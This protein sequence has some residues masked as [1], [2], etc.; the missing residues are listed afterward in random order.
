MKDYDGDLACEEVD[1]QLENNEMSVKLNILEARETNSKFLIDT[2]AQLSFIKYDEITNKNWINQN[3]TI[4]IIGAINEQ[5]CRSVGTIVLSIKM[6]NKLFK[7]KFN[8]TDEQVKYEASGIIGF[9]FMCLF[10]CEI[11]TQVKKMR[12]AYPS[13]IDSIISNVSNG[14]NLNKMKNEND[15]DD[16]I[17]NQLIDKAFI[18]KLVVVESEKK[19]IILKGR[20]HNV[21]EIE[22][23][24]NEPFVCEKS[25]ITNGILVANTIAQPFNGLVKIMLLNMNESDVHIKASDIDL[26]ISRLEDFDIMEYDA[27]QGSDGNDRIERI[28]Q[29][30]NLEHCNNEEKNQILD[31][32]TKYADLFY[33]QGE[34]LS[35]TNIV[36][37]SIELKPG[38]TPKKSKSYRLPYSHQQEIKKQVKE[39][40]RQDMIEETGSPWR[41]PL[42]LV[43]KK[44]NDENKKWRL[45]MDFREVNSSTIQDVYPIP[46]ISEILENLGKSQY[47]SKLDMASGYW[48]VEMEEES[49]KITA[50][51]ADGKLYAWKRMPFGLVNSQAT[52]QRL[53]NQALAGLEGFMCFVYLDDVIIYGKSLADH[54][55]RLI[56]IFKEFRKCNLKLQPSKCEFLCTEI[57]FLGHIVSR[58]GVRVDPKKTEAV[59]KFPIPKTRKQIKSF[60]GFASYYRKF[61][62]RFAKIAAPINWLLRK[63]SKYE[64]TKECDNA[65]NE[66]KEKLVNPPILIFPDYEKEFI[67]TVDASN[68]AIGAI[69]SQGQMTKNASG[70]LPIA[71]ASRQFKDNEMHMSSNDKELTAILFGLQ[72]F[73]PYVLDRRFL[74]VTDCN[75]L[76]YLMKMKNCVTKYTRW[77]VVLGEYNFDIMHKPGILNS[78]ADAL[79]RI[80]LN[81]DDIFGKENIQN[82]LEMKHESKLRI[83]TRSMSRNASKINESANKSEAVSDLNIEEGDVQNLKTKNFDLTLYI[84]SDEGI[85][86]TNELCRDVPFIPE[87]GKIKIVERNEI[88]MYLPNSVAEN[89]MKQAIGGLKTY[90]KNMRRKNIAIV[91]ESKDPKFVFALKFNLM[92]E[93][94]KNYKIKIFTA[95]IIDVNDE[96]DRK[97]I[98]KENHDDP[99]GGHLGYQKTL[100]KIKRK[101][102]WKNLTNDVRQYV[103]G[104]V[105]CKKSKVT[106][107][108]KMPM[109]I[110]STASRPYETVWMDIV[111]PFDE[112]IYGNKYVITFQDDLTKFVNAVPLTNY[113][114]FTCAE[115]FVNE[116]I[117]VHGTPENILTDNGSNFVSDMFRSVCE[118]LNINH[119]KTSA[120]MPS[121]NPIERYHRSLGNYIHAFVDGEKAEWD[122]WIRFATSVY[123]NSKHETT[124]FAPHFLLYGK[125]SNIPNGLEGEPQPIYNYENYALIMRNKFQNIHKMARENTLNVKEQRKENYDR[126]TNPMEFRAG[127]FVLVL[128]KE[129]IKNKL[130]SP[131]EGPYKVIE[132]T[133]DENCLIEINGK[134]STVHKNRLK[135]T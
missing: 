102:N 95:K 3:E 108:T 83:V 130:Q 88:S 123:N 115:A 66:L 25:K 97:I 30:I 86:M 101:F 93:F 105:I 124:N 125:Q 81:Q 53:M 54:N 4:S 73:R 1:M 58:D 23:D 65:F 59:R 51:Q 31:I 37:H 39:L 38:T 103:Q 41:T 112:S 119:I 6:N 16:G 26:K 90:S 133:S 52:F 9:D 44:S 62:D 111:G 106:T 48:Q 94:D 120:Y 47:F 45:V 74:I 2:G 70:D 40:V 78:N 17:I 114:S 42:L 134:S 60:M 99:L 56:R 32:C 113:T 21:I 50:F 34:V 71:Y 107:H 13:K 64:W 128:N 8:V 7:H 43:P 46:N 67:I 89:Q 28:Q 80:K 127:D 14:M 117:C 116:I 75:S 68:Y 22:T 135:L 100:E 110:T 10:K 84:I 79:S 11:N 61:I 63:E 98:M 104:C 92:K 87:L 35:S 55:N 77:K 129:K 18:G 76:T 19:T 15:D 36:K 91:I 27:E 131:Y 109:K 96:D 132:V 69:L 29:L 85:Y 121:S 20:A 24:Q 118:I 126:K 57:N 49:K 33:L 72:Q 12:I 5:K 122:R 82:K